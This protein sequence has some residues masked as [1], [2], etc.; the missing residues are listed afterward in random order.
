[1]TGIAP[2][3][4]GQNSTGSKSSAKASKS[5]KSTGD[6]IHDDDSDDSEF[7]SDNEFGCGSVNPDERAKMRL[8]RKAELARASRKRKKLYVK[9]LEEK[10]RR[11]QAR[12]DEM[13]NQQLEMSVSKQK[14][15]RGEL[16]ATDLLAQV[17]AERR[18]SIERK[19]MEIRTE[20]NVLVSLS[21]IAPLDR[22]QVSQLKD[23]LRQLNET[24]RENYTIAKYYLD[25]LEEVMEPST[26]VKF[27]LIGMDQSDDFYGT[28]SEAD[29]GNLW[30]TVMATE[31]GLSSAQISELM[32]HR[33]HLINQRV[34]LGRCN[35]LLA[36]LKD[37]FNAHTS[38]LPRKMNEMQAIY[39]PVQLAKYYM[40]VERNQWCMKMLQS[41]AVTKVDQMLDLDT[42]MKAD[43][44]IRQA[45][46]SYQQQKPGLE[47]TTSLSFLVN[48]KSPSDS[49][50]KTERD[51]D[52]SAGVDRSASMTGMD[53]NAINEDGDDNNGN[54]DNGGDSMTEL[55]MSASPKLP[56]TLSRTSLDGSD[57]TK[58]GSMFKVG[59]SS[60]HA[61][62][63]PQTS[64]YGA[65]SGQGVPGT[66]GTTDRGNGN[67]QTRGSLPSTPISH[68]S[69]AHSMPQLELLKQSVTGQTAPG[70]PASAHSQQS[71]HSL[72][73]QSHS[74]PPIHPQLNYAQMQQEQQQQ[75]YDFVQ[76]QQQ[77]QMQLQHHHMQQHN[78]FNPQLR[79][80]QQYQQNTMTS[81]PSLT[82][83][84][85]PRS[86]TNDEMEDSQQNNS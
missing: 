33:P 41:N 72:S 7:N 8:A 49:R 74:R 24:L 67:I 86:G 32:E 2:G 45:R 35:M 50:V 12:V 6:N 25:K 38:T 76:Q 82:T 27:A 75:Y 26:Q 34:V 43:D 29:V 64:S 79:Q 28:N 69:T 55:P 83:Q 84:S 46:L 4:P 13:K 31:V 57:D 66:P 54:D 39:T 61:Q 40:W 5:L 42:K 30:N 3:G 78:A 62:K 51:N 65:G 52:V 1:M 70:S 15:P 36:Q 60:P 77:A 81:S 85:S 17:E 22:T 63:T 59:F 21:A 11:L 48:G 44:Y 20:I 18:A 68:S 80:P 10:V 73:S 9:D 71:L 53:G 56:K 19:R 47:T 58:S 23:L 14:D 16:S 37:M